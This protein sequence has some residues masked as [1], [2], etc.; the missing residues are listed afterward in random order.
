MSHKDAPPET[1]IQTT[2]R[3]WWSE[4]LGIG[5]VGWG[6]DKHGVFFAKFAR[7]AEAAWQAAVDSAVKVLHN[8]PHN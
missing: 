5:A 1:A 3:E 6:R 8:A 2:V 4:R 7:D